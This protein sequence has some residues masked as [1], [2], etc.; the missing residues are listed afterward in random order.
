MSKPCWGFYG[1]DYAR[2]EG[3]EMADAQAAINAD[4]DTMEKNA[5]AL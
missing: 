1:L 5:F 3:I 4:V 2:S